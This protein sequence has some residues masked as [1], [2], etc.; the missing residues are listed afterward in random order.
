MQVQPIAAADLDTL[1]AWCVARGMSP[2]PDGWLPPVGYWVPNVL[3]AFMYRTDARVAYVECVIS[4]PDTTKEQRREATLLV[5][6][7]IEGHAAREGFLYLVGLTSIASV[8]EAGRLR[9]Y[10]VSEPKYST[11]VKVLDV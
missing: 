9:G 5:S 2:F 1:N 11:M 6:E 7:A 4:N 10:R 3:G 8:G